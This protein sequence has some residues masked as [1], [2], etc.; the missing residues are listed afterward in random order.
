MRGLKATSPPLPPS[1]TA[2]P[3]Y[4]PQIGGAPSR[5][6]PNPSRTIGKLASLHVTRGDLLAPVSILATA[7]TVWAPKHDRALARV[8]RYLNGTRDVNITY[9]HGATDPLQGYADASFANDLHHGT[10]GLAKSRTG[11]LTMIF[12]AFLC[13]LSVRQTASALST[14]ESEF[15]AFCAATRI[16]SPIHLTLWLI[17]DISDVPTRIMCDNAAAIAVIRRRRVA[18][19]MR[20]VRVN[21]SFTIKAIANRVISVHFCKTNLQ[22]ADYLTKAP[23]IVDFRR[24][25]DYTYGR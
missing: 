22:F 5:H 7:I 6:F 19:R 25:V 1:F 24:C 23:K 4:D 13:G 14:C 10:T 3:D 11:V 21:I 9:K 15:A 20:H 12:G 8:L 18:G 16:I 17:G 2:T